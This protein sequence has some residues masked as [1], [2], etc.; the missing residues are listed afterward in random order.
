MSFS[1]RC[2]WA[3]Y[4][5]MS[6]SGHYPPFY[7]SE[8]TT[9]ALGLESGQITH[10]QIH[11]STSVNG[12]PKTKLPAY[13]YGE[14]SDSVIYHVW[15]GSSAPYWVSIDLAVSQTVTGALVMVYN[16]YAYWIETMLVSYSQ[17]GTVWETHTDLEGN[18]KVS[19]LLNRL[20]CWG[21]T[22]TAL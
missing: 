7:I 14:Q 6:D 18:D 4:V 1:P 11:T 5:F 22:N 2:V 19:S 10:S 17:N 15:R 3:V 21:I 20:T 13:S 16:Y 8:R 12:W 9:R